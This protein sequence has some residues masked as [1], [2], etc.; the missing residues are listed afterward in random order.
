MAK[1]RA[2]KVAD[3]SRLREEV[4]SQK[5]V[6]LLST[7]GSEETLNASSNFALR[8]KAADQGV[9]LEIVKNTLIPLMFPQVDG[10][11]LFVGQTYVVY[12]A[13]VESPQDTDEVT[14]PKSIVGLVQEDFKTQI[15]ILGSFVDGVYFDGA[16]TIALSKT[17][18]K[19]DSL[20][21]LAGLLKQ[22]GGGKIASL[23]K[24]IPSKTARAIG[25]VA[26]T[27]AA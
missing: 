19:Q 1:T 22:L 24:E 3:L 16:K 21:Q 5:A 27:K 10:V 7:K 20:A 23:V 6:V 12:K 9:R 15:S 18:S 4:A 11:P 17:A 8:K 14:V 26:R 2:T 13:G 25:E